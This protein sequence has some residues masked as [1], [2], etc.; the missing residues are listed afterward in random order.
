M[1][2]E[3]AQFNNGYTFKFSRNRNVLLFDM[4]N[5]DKNVKFGK[6][7]KVNDEIFDVLGIR[8]KYS[9]A[10]DKWFLSV[11][12]NKDVSHIKKINNAIFFN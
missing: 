3:Y 4:G 5:L 10:S 1:D 8:G 9:V 12:V 11:S 7:I 2:I 6:N